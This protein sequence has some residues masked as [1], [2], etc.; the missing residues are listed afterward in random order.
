M[1][2][3]S[4]SREGTDSNDPGR[5]LLEYRIHIH[6]CR[7]KTNIGVL[8]EAITRFLFKRRTS[9]GKCRRDDGSTTARTY[10]SFETLQVLGIS[11]GS[12]RRICYV[13][14]I[15]DRPK[16]KCFVM[17]HWISTSF[18]ILEDRSVVSLSNGFFLFLAANTL[19]A[20]RIW[21]FRKFK[22]GSSVCRVTGGC[23]RSGL[24]CWYWRPKQ[25]DEHR[26]TDGHCSCKHTLR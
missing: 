3:A 5:G 25:F 18:G 17:C 6:V 19:Q 16:S 2:N 23:W 10:L 26:N 11:V 1:G 12:L 9:P 7:Q 13:S 21:E 14:T 4:I 8:C 15:F 20:M 24:T 22:Q